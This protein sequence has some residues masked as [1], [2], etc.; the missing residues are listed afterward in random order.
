MFIIQLFFIHVAHHK[1]IKQHMD[2]QKKKSLP[3][4]ILEKTLPKLAR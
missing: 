1:P 4:P 2:L 3:T